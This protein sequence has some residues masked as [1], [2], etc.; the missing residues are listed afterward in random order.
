MW[1]LEFLEMH[2]QWLV[3]VILSVLSVVIVLVKRRIKVVDAPFTQVLERLPDLIIEA[4][5]LF[6]A[7]LSGVQKIA[8]VL[9]QAIVLYSSLG[10][11]VNDIFIDKIRAEVENIL[12][13]PTRK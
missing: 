5:E 12:S 8:Y 11:D 10:G 1:F 7:P 2:W 13:T 6:P 3:T 9:S 4:E